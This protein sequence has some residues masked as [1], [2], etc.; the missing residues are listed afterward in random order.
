MDTSCLPKVLYRSVLGG[1]VLGSRDEAQGIFSDGL[2]APASR[3][4]TSD[5]K[6][7]RVELEALPDARCLPASFAHKQSTPF[8]ATLI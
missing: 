6:L 8:P 2:Q 7:T 4:G 3:A 1:V 5:P